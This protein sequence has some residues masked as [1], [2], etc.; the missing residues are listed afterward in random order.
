MKPQDLR[1]KLYELWR[2]RA[3]TVFTAAVILCTGFA[4]T[5]WAGAIYIL[6]G[7]GED[8]IVLDGSPAE[9]PAYAKRI[10][11]RANGTQGYDLVL[12]AG[13]TANIHHLGET[14]T[15]RTK[16][17]TI[18][19]LL[20]RLE[21]AP[22]PL[23]MIGVDLLEEGVEI[24][25]SSDLSYFH[26]VVEE[27]AYETVRRPN[28]SMEKGT[29][30]VVQEGESG[31]RA[32]IYE[33]S[34]SNGAELS[35]QFVEELNSTVVN[36]I[37]E[38]GTAEPPKPEEAQSPDVAN[39][40]SPIAGVSTNGDGSGVLTLQSGEQ[41]RFRAAK[42]MT[43]TAYTAGYGG[44]GTRTAS[45]T[46]VRVGTVAVDKSVIPLGTRLYIVTND[47]IVYGLSV[48]EDTGVR[49]SKV[50]LYFNTYEECTNFGRRGCTVYILE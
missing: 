32:A 38:Y 40:R 49:G 17:E 31:V 37:I 1:K 19:K 11:Y 9:I 25:I 26:R 15:V 35:R 22:G 3:V 14:V 10:L 21:I 36:E 2:R 13:Q 12:S 46:A 27:V 45:G 8:A 24:T 6:T 47:G 41:Y 50:D 33:V 16:R 42:S 28:P 29:E 20:D 4:A 44:V 23:E 39:N 7:G 18:S 34:W 30:K 43:A 48:A 5:D